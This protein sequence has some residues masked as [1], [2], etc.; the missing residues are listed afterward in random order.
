M[1]TLFVD[2]TRTILQFVMFLL[3]CDAYTYCHTNLAQGA[4]KED[5][6]DFSDELVTKKTNPTDS[7]EESKMT[8]F[9]IKQQWAVQGP[10]VKALMGVDPTEITI[11]NSLVEYCAKEDNRAMLRE[12]GK[13][14][15]L[16]DNE[17]LSNYP[18][19]FY[20]DE[21]KQW[22]TKN[23]QEVPYESDGYGN[24]AL[25]PIEA[26]KRGEIHLTCTKMNT[27]C[28]EFLICNFFLIANLF[29]IT[30]I[31]CYLFLSRVKWQRDNS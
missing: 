12:L 15:Q 11:E 2:I 19:Y 30:T 24:G 7:I 16:I 9:M 29:S 22:Y 4:M 20:M 28:F 27:L 13:D 23:D 26:H 25:F 21:V 18:D 17:R 10:S 3:Q 5:R 14:L 8:E 1:L 31:F 6:C